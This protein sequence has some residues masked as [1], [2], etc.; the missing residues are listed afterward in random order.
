MSSVDDGWGAKPFKKAKLDWMELFESE[1]RRMML[2]G[3]GI[4]P[5]SDVWHRSAPSTCTGDDD[6]SVKL[7]SGDNEVFSV[8]KKVACQAV[9][10]KEMLEG[11]SS[12]HPKLPPRARRCARTICPSRL[13]ARPSR[14]HRVRHRHSAATCR[15]PHPL[16]GHRVLH[17]A[18]EGRERR[19]QQG[20]QE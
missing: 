20:R 6:E 19:H 10:I 11:A 17:L 13:H 3:R 15:E 5:R 18:R 7:Q 12:R 4:W 8:S 16:E 2:E 14:R 9:T 1:S